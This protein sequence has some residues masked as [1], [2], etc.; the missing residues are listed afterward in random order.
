V[1]AVSLV[2]SGMVFLGKTDPTERF[3]LANVSAALLLY[4][5]IDE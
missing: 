3:L 5:A 1:A 4:Q 2:D